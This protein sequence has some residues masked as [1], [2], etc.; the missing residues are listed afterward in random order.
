[1]RKQIITGLIAAMALTSLPAVKLNVRY[2]VTLT[3]GHR[4]QLDYKCPVLTEKNVPRNLRTPAARVGLS[5]ITR[6]F[7]D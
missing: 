3:N 2:I 4:H 6:R 1:M 5:V 7:I